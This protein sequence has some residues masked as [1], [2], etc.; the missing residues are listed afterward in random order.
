MN[1]QEIIEL[2]VIFLT[3]LLAAYNAWVAKQNNDKL[4]KP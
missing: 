2:I 1:A 4:V 3:A